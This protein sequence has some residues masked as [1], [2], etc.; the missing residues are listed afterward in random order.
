MKKTS[1]IVGGTKGIGSVILNKLKKRGDKI[2]TLSRSKL[3]K[4]NHLVCDMS[5]DL[6]EK[7]L[8]NFFKNNKIDNLIF[9]QRY[10]GT[11]ANMDQK[12]MIESSHKII[13]ILKNKLSKNS[14]IIILSSIATT[15]VVEDQNAEYHY[16][17]GAIEGIVKYYAV[18][19]GSKGTRVNCIQPTV[20]FKPENKSFY[21]KKNNLTRKII[22]KITPMKRM[23][24]S[25]DIA[26]LVNFL[27]SDDSSFITGCIIPVDGGARLKS[28][29]HIIKSFL[30]K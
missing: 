4:S 7:Y 18:K 29:E 28:Q 3:K 24:K 5:L 25:E 6:D 23:G 1:L 12:I 9:S 8:I 16:T 10:R 11:V 27:T 26:N 20:I 30:K 13:E 2:F 15:T 19:L 17:R 22:E 21:N 14:S